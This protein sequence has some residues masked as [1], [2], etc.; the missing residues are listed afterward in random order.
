MHVR[1]ATR[2]SRLALRQAEYIAM[3][4]R[5]LHPECRAE[6]RI[7]RTRGDAVL[8]VPLAEAGGK[9]LFVKEIEEELLRGRADMAVHSMKDVP[10]ELPGELVIACIPER[11]DARDMLLSLRHASLDDLPRGASVGTS[12][13]RRQ[14]QLLRLRPDL[15][16]VSLRGNVDTRLRKLTEGFCDAV[17]LAGAGLA[18][19][20]LGAPHVIPLEPPDFL[21]AVGQGALGIECRAD[22]RDLLEMTAP[23]EDKDTRV[24]VEA[25]R[26]FLA[27]LGGNCLVPV[28]AYAR[29]LRPE[30][31][32]IEGMVSD[33][34]GTGSL[35]DRRGGNVRDAARTGRELAE[36]LL[37]LG[38]AEILRNLYAGNVKNS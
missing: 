18:R 14:A 31:L 29:M 36:R 15:R 5:S 11:G 4:L 13:L 32:D 6:L 34:D 23:L 25:E 21:P 19:L 8:D 27:A 1:I 33:T 20:G 17:V 35:R 26:A 10:A 30:H 24:C 16:V 22:R 9:G 2:G 7:I 38:A 37:E 28:A 12:S 3:R